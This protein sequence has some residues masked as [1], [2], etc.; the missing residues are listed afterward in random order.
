MSLAGAELLPA[1]AGF[2]DRPPTMLIG[3]RW[4][5]AAGGETLAT[6]DPATGAR[7]ALVPAGGAEDV[8][9]AVSAARHAFEQGSWSR[10]TPGERCRLLWRLADLVEANAAELAELET[11]DNGK[12]L[13]AAR[14]GDIPAAA[15]MFRYMSGWATKLEGATIP[16]GSPGSFH[17]YTRPEPV[18]VVGAI[19]PWNYPLVLA[20]RKLAPA[21]A[22]G[23]TVVLKPAEETPLTALRLGELIAEAGF[24]DG[25]VNIVTGLGET[26]G[27]ALAAHP[28]V[29]RVTFTGSTE[30]G[31]RIVQAASGN[32]KRVALELGGKSPN[33]VLEDA[34]IDAAIRGAARAIFTNAGQVCYAGSRL[35]VHR[36]L[37][38]R[39]LSGLAESAAA[40]RLGHGMAPDT[41]MG[42]VVS[43]EQLRRV[44]GHMER[45]VAQGAQAVVGGCRRGDTGYFVEP[46]IY[47]G[48]D[49]TTHLV[50]EEVF[51]PVLVAAPFDDLDEVAAR[52]NR[53]RYGLA[54]GVW[55][56]DVSTAHR[57]AARL[58]V[59][60]V[61]I[62]G[63]GASDVALPYGGVRQS[64]WGR[65]KGREGVEVFTE[66]KTVVVTL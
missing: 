29:D 11:L 35:Y 64:G 54:A 14:G 3:G 34:D 57:F 51:G 40:I 42:P 1:T 65:E 36:R 2:L 55:T 5:G 8:D 15:E 63:Y 16:V 21:L 41:Q 38:D 13:F 4:V 44:L 37:F 17:A 60:T 58:R 56:R 26:A 50:R 22:V 33:I 20:S 53:S 24:P 48:L 18:G 31:R 46:T 10:A 62:N 23:C 47:T 43:E 12:P 19:I 32:L 25:V 49:D 28:D 9:A 45:G 27:T 7:L 30:V 52:A 66:T 61:W 6:L 59:G 39:V